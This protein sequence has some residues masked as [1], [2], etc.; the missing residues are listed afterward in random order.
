MQ[1]V[2][3]S[4]PRGVD[5][6][7]SYPN[8]LDDPGVESWIESEEWECKKVFDHMK[9][10]DFSGCEGGEAAPQA[11]ESL[12]QWHR[13]HPSSHYFTVGEPIKLTPKI[14]LPT[15]PSMPWRD[16]WDVIC[17]SGTSD[18]QASASALRGEPCPQPFLDPKSKR[19]DRQALSKSTSLAEL[20]RVVDGKRYSKQARA[21]NSLIDKNNAESYIQEHL[22]KKGSLFLIKLDHQEGEF[23]VG[24]GR[25]LF[26][27]TLDDD[28][29]NLVATIQY[30]YHSIP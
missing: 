16:L 3:R 29:S 7:Q 23:A 15:N 14:V 18:S 4:D 11:W 24:L 6:M 8:I 1:T 2:L 30:H 19:P 26:D 5:L 13:S 28:V 10:V 9:R 20:N 12:Q 27:K 22:H 25:R 21:T 17:P